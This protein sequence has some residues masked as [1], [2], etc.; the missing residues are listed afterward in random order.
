M[1]DRAEASLML[2]LPTRVAGSGER[3]A[4][5]LSTIGGLFGEAVGVTTS[6]SSQAS[7][8]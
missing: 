7:G 4:R 6:V 5:T 2:D 3:V 1:L 8:I